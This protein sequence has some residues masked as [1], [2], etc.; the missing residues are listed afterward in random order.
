MKTKLVLLLMATIIFCAFQYGGMSGN[1]PFQ[2]GW[3]SYLVGLVA[4]GLFLSLLLE[5]W[6]RFR[7][8]AEN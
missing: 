1:A 2:N 5:G 3:Q 4:M 8:M 7:S 6:M